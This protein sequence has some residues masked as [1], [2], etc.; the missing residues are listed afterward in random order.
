MTTFTELLTQH[1][2]TAFAKQLALADFLNERRW[3]VDIEQGICQFGDDLI[4]PIQLLGTE[5]MGDS[6]W[7]WAWA[8]EASKL[9]PSLLVS[10]NALRELGHSES[11]AEFTQGNF[12]LDVA[13][14]HSLSMI[15]SGI[16]GKSCYYRGPYNGGA[17]FFLI[18]EVPESLLAP[19]ACE[20]LSTVIL[21]VVS[22]FHVPH[23][24]MAESF[25]TSQQFSLESS[26]NELIGSRNRD[27]ITL[28][29]DDLD[30]LK[31]IN[32]R[33]SAQT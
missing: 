9:P 15:A 10:C 27:R 32:I 13:D 25:L 11:I 4:Y 33:L 7:L 31:D 29:F 14:G 21:E 28:N 19:V 12:P 3:W 20:R 26:G 16:D 22:Q 5:S 8:N 24:S 6:T 30:R 18:K 17:L 23:R 2:G 1:V